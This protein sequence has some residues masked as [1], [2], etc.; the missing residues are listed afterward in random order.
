MPL[1]IKSAELGTSAAGAP[2]GRGSVRCHQIRQNTRHGPVTLTPNPKEY[3]RIVVNYHWA[4]NDV[5]V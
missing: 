4:E 2:P 5:L 1:E 3:G